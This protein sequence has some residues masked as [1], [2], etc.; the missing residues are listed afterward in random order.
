[1]GLLLVERWG[2]SVTVEAHHWVVVVVDLGRLWQMRHRFRRLR[3]SERAL[4]L[5]R[6][7]LLL[8]LPPVSWKFL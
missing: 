3:A 8:L 1:M 2:T 4:G 6:G 7:R 5:G